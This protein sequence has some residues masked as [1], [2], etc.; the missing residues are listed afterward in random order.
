MQLSA[1][2]HIGIKFIKD[3]PRPGAAAGAAQCAIAAFGR[4][5]ASIFKAKGHYKAPHLVTGA[6]LG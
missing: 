3:A 4:H 1:R 6:C 5:G 2:L